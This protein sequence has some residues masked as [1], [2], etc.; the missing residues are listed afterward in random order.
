MPEPLRLEELITSCYN[1]SMRQRF[2]QFWTNRGWTE[3]YSLVE[4]FE[5]PYDI[6]KNIRPSLERE[7]D[8]ADISLGDTSKLWKHLNKDPKLSPV[9]S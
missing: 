5:D 1:N 7:F 6:I 2:Q 8:K 4:Q 3:N 9:D